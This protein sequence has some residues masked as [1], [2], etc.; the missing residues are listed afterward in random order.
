MQK[1]TGVGM[2]VQSYTKRRPP[3]DTE[4]A[5]LAKEGMLMRCDMRHGLA[6]MSH[7][8]GPHTLMSVI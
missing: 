5:C 7:N 3:P 1:P 2:G 4:G 6:G 8:D